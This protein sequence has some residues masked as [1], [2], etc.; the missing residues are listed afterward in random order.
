MLYCVRF[1][2]VMAAK[3]SSLRSKIS[4]R[5]VVVLG[6]L[7]NVLIAGST[8]IVFFCIVILG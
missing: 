7:S 8:I 5:V 6:Y 3:T 1:V 2:F 4:G